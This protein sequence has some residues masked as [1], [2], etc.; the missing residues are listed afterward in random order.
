[1]CVYILYV[2]LSMNEDCDF[3]KFI[4]VVVS[5]HRL[6]LMDFRYIHVYIRLRNVYRSVGK[7]K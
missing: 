6:S 2:K 7:S 3:V 1:M 4:S 5:T